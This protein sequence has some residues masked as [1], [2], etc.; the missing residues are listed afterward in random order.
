MI[1]FTITLQHV[2][3]YIIIYFEAKM[4]RMSRH[5]IG[6]AFRCS[7]YLLVAGIAAHGVTRSLVYIKKNFLRF[8][9][10]LPF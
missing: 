3:V 4:E 2:C 1:A 7:A 8:S 5:F 9:K 6:S 10:F